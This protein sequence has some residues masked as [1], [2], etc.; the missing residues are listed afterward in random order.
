[1]LVHCAA[2]PRRGPSG[3]KGSRL[4]EGSATPHTQAKKATS[5]TNQYT[6]RCT[7]P[8]TRTQATTA[9]SP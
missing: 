3:L 7:L 6:R 9:G 5:T 8:S 1:M 2:R 4:R